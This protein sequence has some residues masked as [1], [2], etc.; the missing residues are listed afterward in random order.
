MSA[1]KD[2]FIMSITYSHDIATAI[3][4]V[5]GATM[6]IL[7]RNYQI[8]E[9]A[10]TENYFIRAYQSVT[11]MAK[12]SLIYILVAGVPRVI[13]YKEYEWSSIAGDLQIVA[14]IIKHVVMFLL[15]GTGFYFWI[16]LGKKVRLL[17]QGTKA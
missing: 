4:A 15:V 7:S 17:K 13:F 16:K 11:K 10:Q 12:Y 8:S 3:L 9:N 6:W 1:I 5:S 2:I 14:I